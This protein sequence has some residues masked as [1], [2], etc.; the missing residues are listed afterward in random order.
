MQ[1]TNKLHVNQ[2]APVVPDHIKELMPMLCIEDIAHDT[3]NIKC[4]LT[5]ETVGVAVYQH[6]RI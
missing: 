3:C 6:D 4:V 1:M 2:T 5:V